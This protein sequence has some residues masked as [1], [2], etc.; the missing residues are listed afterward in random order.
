MRSP[1]SWPVSAATAS[2]PWPRRGRPSHPT[3]AGAARPPCPLRGAGGGTL[4]VL[5]AAGSVG[6]IATQLAVS[7][8]V[9]VVGA[10]SAPDHDLVRHLGGVPAGYGAGLAGWGAGV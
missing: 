4:L 3:P 8:G 7:Q 5:G 10:A 6:M 1:P 2:T 9:R